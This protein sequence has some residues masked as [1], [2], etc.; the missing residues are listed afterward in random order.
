MK[1]SLL[2]FLF[3]CITCFG[4]SFTST[5]VSL[6]ISGREESTNSL[7]IAVTCTNRTDNRLLFYGLES[8]MIKPWKSEDEFCESGRFGAGV[9]V[10]LYDANDLQKFEMVSMH[11]GI[12]GQ[13]LFPRDT[14]DKRMKIWTQ[15]FLAGTRVLGPQETV[16]F[17]LHI[18]I[19]DFFLPHGDYSVR[20]IY[21]SGSALDGI[22][23]SH[24]QVCKDIAETN[25]KLFSGCIVSNKVKFKVN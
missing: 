23:L 5:A 8:N 20:L 3:P 9:A 16:R 11:E 2:I 18:N 7:C 4:Q 15:K 24:D 13:Q 25:S 19:E 1:G 21:Y 14:L 22:T 6:Q 10:F 17:V 12:K